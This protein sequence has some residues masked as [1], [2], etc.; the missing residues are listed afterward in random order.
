MRRILVALVTA[1][2]L[3]L[4]AFMLF[5]VSVVHVARRA[6]AVYSSGRCADLAAQRVVIEHQLGR[7]DADLASLLHLQDQ[8][9]ARAL[10]NCS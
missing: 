4:A 10:S 5:V 8:A 3:G 9:I 1:L 6:P 2:L 7:T